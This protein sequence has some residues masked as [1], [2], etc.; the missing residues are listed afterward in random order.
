MARGT[1]NVPHTVIITIILLRLTHSVYQKM[2]KF[3]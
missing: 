3:F 1:F 2:W